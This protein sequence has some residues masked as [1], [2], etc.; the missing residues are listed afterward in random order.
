VAPSCVGLVFTAPDRPEKALVDGLIVFVD[1]VEQAS[2]LGDGE[3]DQAT[4]SAW[5]ARWTFW[6][7]RRVRA[8][9]ACALSTGGGPPFSTCVSSRRGMPWRAWRG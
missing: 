3:C 4:G 7:L 1:Q 8:V 2:D 9:R 6:P 5:A